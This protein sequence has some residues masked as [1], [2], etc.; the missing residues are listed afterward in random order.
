[1][2][3]FQNICKFIIISGFYSLLIMCIPFNIHRLPLEVRLEIFGFLSHADWTR[4][5]LHNR[6]IANIFLNNLRYLA[7][8]PCIDKITF[9]CPL[10]FFIIQ[11]L[12]LSRHCLNATIIWIS[13]CPYMNDWEM[14][15]SILLTSRFILRCSLIL[16]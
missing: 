14:P 13:Q 6:R 11:S 12:I 1:M 10:L 8:L 4:L 15:F 7:P 16:N 9:V 3:K 2:L 5:A